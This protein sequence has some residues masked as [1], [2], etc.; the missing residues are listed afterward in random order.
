MYKVRSVLGNNALLV[1]DDSNSQESIFI[2]TGIGFGKKV[3]MSVEIAGDNVTRYIQQKGKDV[4]AQVNKNDV[5]YLEI[6]NE[7][8]NDACARFN[9][10]DRNILITLADHIAFAISRMDSGLIISNPFKNDIKLMFQEEYEVAFKA[11][12][13]IDRRLNRQ[14][15]E[16]EVSYITLHLHG[17]RSDM[18]VDQSLLLASI[19]QDSMKEIEEMLKIKIDVNSLSYSRLLTHLKYLLLRCNMKEKLKIDMDEFTKTN[20]PVSYSLASDIIFKFSKM[21]RVEI[22]EIEIGYLALH[23]ERICSTAN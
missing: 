18:K 19:V 15:N 7:L 6:A 5:V 16:D 2:G 8:I 23:I 3:G 4:S 13:I 20:F 10:F 11:V 14:I 22:D 17:A 12:D 1:L 9:N 21:L